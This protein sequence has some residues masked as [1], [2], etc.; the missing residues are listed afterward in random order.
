MYIRLY[1]SKIVKNK[2][3]CVV[4]CM[5]L[6]ELIC[7]KEYIY[8]FLNNNRKKYCNSSNELKN[9]LELYIFICMSINR[10]LK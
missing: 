1:I 3:D 8:D 9:M 4:I 5:S 2:N 6:D 10:E 7:E